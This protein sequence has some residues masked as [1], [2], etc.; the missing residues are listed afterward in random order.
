MEHKRSLRAAFNMLCGQF[1]IPD[2][3]SPSFYLFKLSTS[4]YFE[5]GEIHFNSCLMVKY[6]EILLRLLLRCTDPAFHIFPS[7]FFSQNG[8]MFKIY[9]FSL[10]TLAYSESKKKCEML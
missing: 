4:G 2:L 5:H 1:D 9:W 8:K 6:K 3:D 7:N 10:S